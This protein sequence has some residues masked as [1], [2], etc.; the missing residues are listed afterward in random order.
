[1]GQVNGRK[2]ADT[3]VAALLAE[4]V[5]GNARLLLSAINVGEVYSFVMHHRPNVAESW[6]ESPGTAVG[7]R[8]AKTATGYSWIWSGISHGILDKTQ[9]A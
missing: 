8:R 7:R 2:P 1:M 9:C 5:A 3:L 6:R 4:G